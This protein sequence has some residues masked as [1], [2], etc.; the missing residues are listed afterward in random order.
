MTRFQ[1]FFLLILIVYFVS[2]LG[3]AYESAIDLFGFITLIG[4]GFYLAVE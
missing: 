1:K 3:Q 4:I 2:S